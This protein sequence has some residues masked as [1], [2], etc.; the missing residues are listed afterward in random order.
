MSC[1]RGSAGV[2][3]R[4]TTPDLLPASC[5]HGDGWREPGWCCRCESDSGYL[6]QTGANVIKSQ[7]DRKQ[8]VT[9]IVGTPGILSTGVSD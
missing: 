1:S 7:S 2:S 4:S 5:C 9:S 8:E 3:G 6:N